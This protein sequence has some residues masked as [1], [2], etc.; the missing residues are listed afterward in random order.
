MNKKELYRLVDG[1]SR[2][3]SRSVHILPEPARR[4]VGQA[5]LL[6]RLLDSFEDDPQLPLVEKRAAL[7]E[8]RSALLER[9]LPALAP[10]LERLDCPPDELELAGRAEELFAVLDSFPEKVRQAV[11][12][13]AAEM[14]DGMKKF[15]VGSRS[16][17]KPLL[18]TTAELSEYC[19][20]VAGTVGHMLTALFLE[21]LPRLGSGSRRILHANK[22][23]FGTA[24]QLVNIIKDCGKDWQEGRCFIPAELFRKHALKP[25]QFF[26]VGQEKTKPAIRERVE[27]L[28]RELLEE[29]E[30]RLEQ[31]RRYSAALPATAWRFRLFCIFPL[32]LA[33][34]TLALLK[35]DPPAVVEQPGG[36]KL[37]RPQVKKLLRGSLPAAVSNRMLERLCSKAA[38]IPTGKR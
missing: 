4:Y 23:A 33:Y 31:A 14:A 25:A 29:A 17:G 2:T 21:Q 34:A 26:A 19:Y 1:V 16:G 8:L 35:S 36:V 12:I 38:E 7:S 15:A 32:V 22:E 10:W 28:L 13:Q 18:K 37:S 30:S 5:Y 20:Y 27:A 9:R 11:E 3:F 6:C 24:L